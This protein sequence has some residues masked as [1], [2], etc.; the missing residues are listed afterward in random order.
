MTEGA[1]QVFTL[2]FSY[3]TIPRAIDNAVPSVSAANRSD[4]SPA[5][6]AAGE[7]L[8]DKKSLIIPCDCAIIYM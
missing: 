1:E 5:A 3:N 4:T 8:N 6:C 7:A 2:R